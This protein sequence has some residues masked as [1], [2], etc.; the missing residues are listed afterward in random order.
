MLDVMYDML[1]I[2][3][4]L[5]SLMKHDSMMPH[6]HFILDNLRKTVMTTKQS[7]MHFNLNTSNSLI[8]ALLR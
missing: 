1:T 4:L 7:N 6:V 5:S 2:L 8:S 3:L